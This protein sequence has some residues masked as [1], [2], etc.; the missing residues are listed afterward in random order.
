MLIFWVTG[1]HTGRIVTNGGIANKVRIEGTNLP[2]T[3][4]FMVQNIALLTHFL[5]QRF[6]L[7]F[8]FFIY[9]FLFR[10]LRRSVAL[11]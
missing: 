4:T 6:Y 8:K 9:L 1:P 11:L 3:L 10:P 7:F 5:R 2:S